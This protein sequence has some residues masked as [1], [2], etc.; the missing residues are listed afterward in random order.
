MKILP[1]CVSMCIQ[2][3]WALVQE[4][5][6]SQQVVQTDTIDAGLPGGSWTWDFTIRVQVSHA[7]SAFFPST[8]CVC[9]K[10]EHIWPLYGWFSSL[11]IKFLLT[12]GD[13]VE[14]TQKMSRF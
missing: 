1:G 11:W 7:Q 12:E 13:T 9:Q 8:T 6:S 10:L 2:M 3:A 4:T 5:S 14:S